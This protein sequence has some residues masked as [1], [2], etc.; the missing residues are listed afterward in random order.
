ME[1]INTLY[2]SENLASALLSASCEI[3]NGFKKYPEPEQN[4]LKERKE[5]ENKEKNIKDM[6][7]TRGK[8]KNL[9][10]AG[11]PRL[12]KKPVKNGSEYSL[13]LTTFISMRNMQN[14]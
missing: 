8:N 12:L 10:E 3:L 5:K 1:Q 4:R 2:K 6:A 9:I 13:Y 14:G 11:N 7:E